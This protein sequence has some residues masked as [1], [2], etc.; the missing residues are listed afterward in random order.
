MYYIVG[1]TMASTVLQS[2]SVQCGTLAWV[3]IVG[4][5]YG[6]SV[7]L[8]ESTVRFQYGAPVRCSKVCFEEIPL[9][10]LL[11]GKT[12]MRALRRNLDFPPCVPQ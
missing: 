7:D 6:S 5:P 12:L 4:L 8:R 10:A 11:V 9:W 1:S 2:N 3:S